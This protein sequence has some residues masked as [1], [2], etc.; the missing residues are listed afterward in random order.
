MDIFLSQK[1]PVFLIAEI[2][3]NQEGDFPYAKKLLKLAIESGAD[4]VKFQMYSGN[5][6]VS[7]IE[8]PDRSNHFKKFELQKEQYIESG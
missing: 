3:G 5:T 8:S 4:A 7:K 1:N 6:L 2:G